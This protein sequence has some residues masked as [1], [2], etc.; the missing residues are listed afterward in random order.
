MSTLKNEMLRNWT[1]MRVI[2]LLL[3]GMIV[4]QAINEKNILFGVLGLLFGGLAIC[5]LGCCGG[6][7]CSSSIKETNNSTEFTYEEVV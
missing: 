3:G 6:G 1:P 4:V 5:N 7:A 2:R